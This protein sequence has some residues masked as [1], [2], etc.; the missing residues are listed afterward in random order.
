MTVGNYESLNK[1]STINWMADEDLQSINQLEN[2]SKHYNSINIKLVKCGGLTPA[3]QIIEKAKQLKLKI[4]IGCMTETTIAIS[5]AAVLAPFAN[6][7]DLDG[8]F[9]ISNDNAH[10]TKICNGKVVFSQENGLGISKIK[11]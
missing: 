7:L 1:K 3:L 9:L 10:G 11:L 6:F 2:L 5:A 4:M 8:A